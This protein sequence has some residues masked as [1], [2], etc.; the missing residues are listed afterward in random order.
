MALG[1]KK[2]ANFKSI[3]IDLKSQKIILMKS[4]K[5]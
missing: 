1:S 3:I 5:F 2:E 4:N